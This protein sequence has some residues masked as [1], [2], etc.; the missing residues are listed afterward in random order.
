VDEY[1]W[2]EAFRD[3]SRLIERGIPREAVDA[4]IGGCGPDMVRRLGEMTD[5][6]VSDFA[7]LWNDQ[8][9]AI[10]ALAAA[11]ASV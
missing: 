8:R 5:A 4:A 6:Q 1:G 10:A 9:L 7:R 3:R 2:G 11:V